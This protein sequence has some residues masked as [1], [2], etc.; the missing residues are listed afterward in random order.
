MASDIVYEKQKMF[1]CLIL[2]DSI[3][4]GTQQYRK[5]CSVVAKSGINS[6]D[7]NKTYY[8]E[9]FSNNI[10]ISLGSNDHHGI[11]TR[12]ELENLRTRVLAK[13]RVF[14]IL[15]ANS[16]TQKIVLDIANKNGDIVLPIIKLQSDGV[17]PTGAGYKEL[18][19]KIK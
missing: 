8:G 11:N 12:K 2:G 17:H 10:I 7:F 13:N 15:P 4:V 19:G 9:F 1:E 6:K 14:W 3:A 18:G 5:D 16:D